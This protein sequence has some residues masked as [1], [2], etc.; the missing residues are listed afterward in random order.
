MLQKIIFI[1][2]FVKNNI[3]IFLYSFMKKKVLKKDKEGNIIKIFESCT[4]AAAAVN[5]ET[6]VISKC[7]IKQKEYDGFY[8]EY[9]N[10]VKEIDNSGKIKCPYCDK[11]FDT[12][13]GLCKHI[14]KY[15]AHEGITQEQLLT[16]VKYGGIRPSCKCGCGGYT[17]IINTNGVHFADYIRGH[18]NRVHNNWGHNLKAQENSAKTRREQYKSGNRIQWN[19][20]KKWDEVY[21]QEKQ[22]KLR[23]GLIDGIHERINNSTFS[24]SSKL[25][26][27]FIENYIKPY[28]VEYQTQFYIPEIKQF[29]DIY[30]P[31]LNLII[32]VNGTYWHCDRRIYELGSINDIQRDKIKK[33]NIKY[34]FLYRHGY[35]LLVIWEYDLKYNTEMIR[36]TIQ[37]ILSKG[38]IWKHDLYDFMHKNKL[39]NISVV[40]LDLTFNNEINDYKY[41]ADSIKVFEDE[42]LYKKDI[43]KSRLLNAGKLTVNKIYARKC[44]IEEITHREAS[45]FLEKNHLQGKISGCK[46]LALKYVDNIVSVMVFGRLR[47]NLGSSAKNGEYE[48]LR[49]CSTLNTNV[50]GG[51]GKLFTYFTK[52][53]QPEKI[54]SYCDK[55]WG[56]G[57]FYEKIGMEYS[58]DSQRNYYYVNE[59]ERKRENRFSY[60]KDILVK[61]GFNKD[62]SEKQIMIERGFHRI[63]DCGCKVFVWENK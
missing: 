19:K 30:I 17:T 44:D 10:E 58:H 8:Y 63:Y 28:G 26:L 60:R 39:E 29:S 54:I 42:W 6:Y 47:K 51:A 56:D 9:L 36:D 7:I 16:D 59:L 33:D 62:I 55:R 35:N 48:L 4:E 34:D 1:G 43:V 18:W 41:N 52:K 57:L 37:Y 14:F 31:S 24:L 27:N 40:P 38:E 23:Q 21:N 25:E 22:D 5:K 12:Y 53:Y 61:M 32:E 49:F 15:S 50:I 20:G 11:Y 3:P 46:Y 2:I 45:I 13:N